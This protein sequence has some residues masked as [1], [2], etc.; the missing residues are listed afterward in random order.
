MRE[1]ERERLGE[2]TGGWVVKYLLATEK[3]GW[4]VLGIV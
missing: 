4:A 2:R 1:R 3:S